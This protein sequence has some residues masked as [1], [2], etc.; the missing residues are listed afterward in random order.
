MFDYK[1]IL[2]Y[3]TK[4]FTVKVVFALLGITVLFFAIRL[5][6][7]EILPIFSDEGIYINWAK[8]AKNDA[9]WRFISLTDGKQPLQTWLT[10]PFL[11]LLPDNPLAAGRLV[12]VLTGFAA[13]AGV[14]SLLLYLFNMRT[15]LFGM[16]LYAITPFFVFYDR[17]A[18]IDSGVNAAF[19]WILFFSILLV[20]TNRLDIALLYGLIAGVGLLA[21]SSVRLFIALTAF[22]PLITFVPK[23][24]FSKSYIHR[25][26]NF[27]II[28]SVGAVLAFL[29]Y[30][31]QRLSPFFHIIEQK[32]TTFILTLSEF[33]AAPFQVVFRNIPLIP[34]Y[35][36]SEM[37]YVVAIFGL[38][39]LYKLIRKETTLGMY[40]LVWILVP[41]VSVAFMARVL[42]PR[43][44]I[45][46]ATLMLILAAYFIGSLKD[47]RYVLGSFIAV[48]VSVAYFNYT[49]L[50]KPEAI[51]FPQVD[52]GQY[53][54][55]W[56]AG[57]GAKEIMEYARTQSK[58]KPVVIL[59]EGNFGMAGDVLNS[60][61]TSSDGDH[62]RI[63]GMW[64]LNLEN[65]QEAQTK[66]ADA[67]VFAVF[68]H[69]TDFPAD[70][71]V[72]L[73]KVYDKPG[74]ES[75]LHFYKVRTITD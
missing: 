46:F 3:I 5:T 21:K 72:D 56:P 73:V 66:F 69:R 1:V 34:Y 52:R 6:N 74:D 63:E 2:E 27:F 16:L 33:I 9:S 68:P 12:S 57:W 47:K 31:V 41:F 40:F 13:M 23:K 58:D 29:I 75:Q 60:L 65:I 10:I 11:A 42:F 26:V 44:I 38:I 36:S 4:T 20:R 7:I 64:P 24:G 15:A 32:N 22:A 28:F 49:L 59:A 37:G 25:T 35:I 19:I 50:F 18:L 51:P 61:K 45:F 48:I 55:G 53:I 17:M 39:G 8:I 54:E 30:N 43:Y 70:W 67:H 14:F 71:P 62:I